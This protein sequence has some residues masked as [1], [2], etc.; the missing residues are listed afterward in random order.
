MPRPCAAGAAT[1]VV[2]VNPISLRIPISRTLE[3]DDWSSLTAYLSV[4]ALVRMISAGNAMKL[5]SG[6]FR[7]SL[8]ASG[9]RS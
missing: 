9:T 8:I 1:A 3:F 4:F 5:P 7:K 6:A 2:A